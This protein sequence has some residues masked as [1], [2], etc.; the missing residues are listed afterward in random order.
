MV[1]TKAPGDGQKAKKGRRKTSKSDDK[2]PTLLREDSGAV[3]NTVKFML[4]KLRR[5]DDEDKIEDAVRTCH[6]IATR[7]LDF[8]KL[9]LEDLYVQGQDFPVLDK[10]FYLTVIRVI[11]KKKTETGRP[12]TQN[13]NFH[14]ELLQFFNNHFLPLSP[15][16]NQRIV[17]QNLSH[18]F[19][20]MA[21]GMATVQSTNI[22]RNFP[23]YV[24]RFVNTYFREKLY[25]ENGWA[26]SYKMTKLQKSTFYGALKA[27]KEDILFCRKWKEDGYKSAPHFHD[28]LEKCVGS[29]YPEPLDPTAEWGLYQD[30]RKQPF[31]YLRYMVDL[32]IEF[33]AYGVKLMS[34]FCL[35][36]SLSPRY[37]KLDTSAIID[38]LY[39]TE[40]VKS[41]SLELNLPNLKGK[42]DMY[43]SPSRVFGREVTKQEAFSFNTAIWKHIFRFDTNKYSRHLLESSDKNYVFDTSILTDGVGVSVLQVKKDRVGYCC[44]ANNSRALQIVEIDVPYLS[45]LSR[46]EK[47]SI[48]ANDAIVGA[49]PGKDDIVYIVNECGTKLRYTQQQRAV[50]CR[51]KKNKRALVR[52]KKTTTC[53]NGLTVEEVEQQIMYNAKS[54]LPGV[55]RQYI[56]QR[57]N[58]EALVYEPLYVRDTL[59]KL[60]FSA[61]SHKMQS[62]DRLIRR[63][64]NTFKQ[65]GKSGIVIAWGNWGQNPNMKNCIPTPGIGLRKTVARK[66]KVLNIKVGR[67]WEAYTSCT[68]H[69]CH[70]STKYCKKRVFFKENIRHERDVHGLLRCQNERCGR[71]WNRNVL[72][73]TNIL[74]IALA[75]LQGLDRPAHF[76]VGHALEGGV[77]VEPPEHDGLPT[78]FTQ[79]GGFKQ[80]VP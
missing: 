18:V 70:G 71:R 21:E 48:L 58:L 35:R 7:V 30:V 78:N 2:P 53:S 67:E 31:T 24:K 11:T 41:L 1:K 3:Y 42:N 54:C 39:T 38:L 59:R 57:R 75:T 45:D 19:S 43:K 65:P 22:T 76:Q 64:A 37:I 40:D 51:F 47:T 25:Q 74:E 28:F 10:G 44:K 8:V 16:G 27:V 12:L 62:E 66:G 32:N 23:I 20:Y 60:R 6:A 13:A 55:T 52:M 49:D 36:S 72:G 17:V 14:T 29:M 33:E 34:P 26:N 9:Y 73:A 4:K 61:C 68:C 63:I 79:E 15:T 46:E 69:D 56:S 5:A 50:E 77:G 80:S